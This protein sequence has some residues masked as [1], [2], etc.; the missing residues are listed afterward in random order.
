ML[1]EHEPQFELIERSVIR[2]AVELDRASL[3]DLL[4]G[5]Y[6]GARRAAAERVAALDRACA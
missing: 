6:R 4:Q 1:A 5:T 2:E 3:L